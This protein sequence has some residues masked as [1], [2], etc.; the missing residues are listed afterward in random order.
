MTVLCDG[1]I[2]K[3][4]VADSFNMEEETLN[5]TSDDDEAEGTTLDE[6]DVTRTD[7]VDLGVLCDGEINR[8]LVADSFNIEE[9]TLRVTSDDDEAE[10][11]TPDESV[12]TRTDADALDVLC[13]G[14]MTTELVADCFNIK[15]ETLTNIADED[16]TEG[17]LLDDSGVT[18]TDDVALTTLLCDGEI[19]RELVANSFN[20][21]EETRRVTSDD[22][23]A[24]GNTLA[25]SG[26]TRTDVVALG[27]LCDGEMTTELVA[28][29]FNIKEETLTNIADEDKT[30]GRILDDSGV[31]ITDDVALTTLLC[32]G[33][34]NRELVANSFNIEEETRRVTSD[35]DEAEGNTLAESGGTRTDAVALGVLCDGEMTTELVADCFNVKVLTLTNIADEDKTEGRILDE[36]GATRTDAVALGVKLEESDVAVTDA[37]A[38]IVLWDCEGQAQLV[39]DCITFKD[40]K[41]GNTSYDDDDLSADRKLA[42]VGVKPSDSVARAI[43]CE[44]HTQ[45]V[46]DG[47]DIEDE[48]I[49][50][51]SDDDELEGRTLLKFGTAATDAVA[52]TVLCDGKRARERVPDCFEVEVESLTNTSDDDGEAKNGT[53]NDVD[54]LVADCFNIKEE[55]LTNIA[56]E[57]ETK[58]RTVDDSGVT[59]T[60]DVALRVLCDGEINRELVANSF[61]IEEETLRVTSD[62]DEAEG[63]TP[64]ESDVTRTD[65]VPLDVLCDGEMTTEL[66]SDCFNVKEDTLTNIADEDKTEGRILDESGATRTDAVSLGVKREE[67]DVCL[68]DAVALIVLWDCEGQA[69]LV[70]DC[71][72]LK[73]EKRGNTSDDDDDLSADSKLA[74][75]G[76]KPSDSFARAVLCETH[77]QLV[78]DGVDIEDETIAN[79]S[80]DDELEGR[81]LVELDTTA[82]DAVALTVLCD[83]NRAREPVSDCF[84]VEVESLTNTSD[85]DCEAKNGTLDEVDELVAD[86]FNIKEET[87]RV[88][89]DDDEAEG[90]TLDESGVSITDVV[91]VGV[92]WDGEI[93]TELVA[94]SFNI[95]EETLRVTSDDDEAEGGTPDESGV[96]RTAAVPLDV[97]CD[98]EMTTELV[99]DCF[100]VKE[101]TLTN[102]ADEDKTEGR[103]LDE[104]GATRTDAVSLGVKREEYDVCL[105]DAVAL[106]VLWDC[107]GQAQ[108][109]T[110]CIALKDEKRGNT[111]DDDDDLRADSKLAE[112]GVKP[113]DSVA[114]AVLC[115]THTQLVADGVDVQDETIANT[116]DDDE[117]EGRTLVE[118]DTTATDA[119]ALTVLCDG[120]RAR[121]P[122]SDCFEVEVESLT[123]T[124]N[125]DCEAK[126]GTLD[127]VDELVADCFNI[128]EGT[129]RVTLDDDEAEGNTL[130]E[131]GVS[132]TDVV[133]VGVLCDGE[134]NTELVANSFN[135]EEETLRV[136]S[137]D[138]EAEGNTFAESG[139]TRTAAVTLDVLCDGEMTTELVADCFNVKEET[140][141]NIADEDKTEG[142]ILDESGATRTDAVALDVKLEEYDV[143]VTDAVALIV[144]WDCEGQAQ[145]V[146]DCITFKDE[147]L[148]NTSDDDDDLIADRKLAE[149]GVKPSDSVARAILRETH[150]Q[151][152]ADGVDIEEET[153]AN[154]SDDDE[155]EGRTLVEFGTAATD[156]VALTVLC[157][158]NRARERVPDCFEVEV[159]SLTNT[160]DDD[161]E[162]KNGTLNDVD[163]LVADCFNIKEETLTN[164]VDEGETKGRTVDDSG[165][166]IT[167]VVSVGVLCDGEINR[168]LVA[169]SFNIEEETLRVTS[170]DDE[171]EGTTPDESDV[172]RTDAVPLDVLCDGEMTTELVSDCFNVKEDT[173]TNIADEDK[174]EGRILDESGAT[175]TDAVSLGVKREEYDVCLT[176]AVALIVLWDCEG[177]AQLV[178]DCIALKDEKRGNTSD[179]DD[180]LSA[181]SKLAEVGVKPSDSFARAVLC[182]THTQL[183]ADGVDIEDETIANTSDDDELEGRTLVELDTTA[184]DAV[185]LTVLCD[186]NRAREPVSDCFEVEVESLTNTSDDDCEAKNGTLDEVDELV[187]DC[188]NIKE[189]TVRVPLDDDEAEGNTLD[190]SGVSITD[191]VSVGVLCDSEIN[192]ELVA[193]SFNIEEETLRVTSDDDEAEGNTPDE[194]DVTRTDAVPLDVLCD[195]EMTTELVADFFNIKV[196]TLTNIADEDKT[197]G[198]ILDES[199]ASR[200]DAVALGV[201]PEESDVAVTDAIALIV[202][203]DCE[204][205]AQLVT[206]CI[207][208]KDEKLGNTSDDDDDLIADRKLAEVG[209][210]PSDSVARAVLCETHTQLA[211]GV[212]IE[213][214][215]FANTSDDDESEGRPLVEFGTTTLTVLCDG[216]GVRERVPDCFKVE[217]ESLTNTSDDDG[218]AKNGTL[219]E[220]D[221]TT[222]DAVTLAVLCDGKMARVRGS[223]CFDMEVEPLTDTSGDN[224]E[225]KGGTRNES[226]VTTTEALTL[227]LLWDCEAHTQLVADC[228]NI[229]DE[230]FTNTLDDDENCELHTQLDGDFFDIVD[231]KFAGSSDNDDGTEDTPVFELNVGVV[232]IVATAVRGSCVGDKEFGA[233]ALSDCLG[234]DDVTNVLVVNE[235]EGNTLVEFDVADPTR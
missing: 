95:E 117:L 84:E 119:V 187:A 5:V 208:F 163:E 64:D 142:R 144:L 214:E 14:E 33:E 154:T 118:L 136:T 40:E 88:P 116:S 121:E 93:N 45:L 218:E 188:F 39:T 160:S 222:T 32:D 89:L 51:T 139:G 2:N 227:T 101:E 53:L 202:L 70:T 174:T 176:D 27:V 79:T 50:N 171:A 23:E 156:A 161:C 81:T 157:D 210:K 223:D 85:D 3:E 141:T 155:S 56:D 193:N 68:T 169:N 13:D 145:L 108:L 205:Q 148:G 7:A 105:T 183:V 150:T 58:G 149:V 90:N 125:D 146:T 4:L 170:D 29:C 57:G 177:Q 167:D 129:V 175:R 196:L 19:N 189:E 12:V 234:T 192:R 77:T 20:I 74:E 87:V 127:E 152:V 126:N 132:R 44:T 112:V 59:I 198:R 109:V 123:N 213:D 106:I 190:E 38:L 200:T 97:L 104:S 28:D 92:L 212:D 128:K 165:V 229:E 179:D 134:I 173:L 60:D 203:W 69:Q 91:S 46:A 52:L 8:E 204:G 49:A 55:T 62:D 184:T 26:G 16:K 1:E 48:A 138:D 94:N 113:S 143:A 180:D 158:G 172:T 120:N 99:S 25:E 206:D 6:S 71:I 34:I 73:D 76:V 122:V 31:T 36:S 42:E 110:D 197:E 61:N 75:V 47:V 194:S 220:F 207:T 63:T 30:E 140:L 199:G 224:D 162:A 78:A 168:E 83:G 131:S 228:F 233:A 195:G 133:S 153:F 211:D 37:I 43:L 147:K 178:T 98:G 96:T 9:E 232:N 191:V 185:A 124:S 216:K 151:L 135:I 66:V 209:V 100:N 82:T 11:N 225:A 226:D 215:T 186:G 15:E 235:T 107:E 72:A 21:E 201:K 41:L 80:D 111:S 217:V 231:E 86:C 65:A 103:I 181:D 22:D 114:R 102:I 35:D 54:E 221:V 67:Y 24:E 130:D 166:T 164:I 17:R 18:I 182:E 115:E 137:D 230:T 10:G 159:E 219:D